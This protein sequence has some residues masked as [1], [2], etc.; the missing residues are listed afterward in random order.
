MAMVMAAQN[1]VS[2]AYWPKRRYQLNRPLHPKGASS[3]KAP[4]PAPRMVKATITRPS[5]RAWR[6]VYLTGFHHRPADH[7]ENLLLCSLSTR[8][9]IR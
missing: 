5:R 6:H 7:S 3:L 9:G 4:G 8:P 2:I 1:I